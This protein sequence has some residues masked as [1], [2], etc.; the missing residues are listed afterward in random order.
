MACWLLLIRQLNMSF[1]RS[2]KENEHVQKHVCDR[3]ADFLSISR[4]EDRHMQSVKNIIEKYGLADPVTPDTVGL[5]SNEIFQGLYDRLVTE[6]SESLSGALRVGATIEDLDISDLQHALEYTA[7]QDIRAVYQNLMKGSRNH[8]RIFV[9]RLSLLGITYETQ[10]LTQEAVDAIVNGAM[11]RGGL[12]AGGN[13]VN[14]GKR[15]RRGY[16]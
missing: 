11:E 6:G 4:S 16:Q 9:N 12:D 8:L 2:G 13:Q 3:I 7:N 1:G 15:R 10:Y 14:F 5:F